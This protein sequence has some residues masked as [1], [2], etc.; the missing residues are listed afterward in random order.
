MGSSEALAHVAGK[1][2]TITAEMGAI[3]RS[4]LEFLINVS[5]DDVSIGKGSITMV[6][7]AGQIGEFKPSPV[8]PDVKNF[9]DPAR[10]DV[11]GMRAQSRASLAEMAEGLEGRQADFT[12][13]VHVRYSDEDVNMHVN[14]ASYV[15]FMEDARCALMASNHELANLVRKWNVR[16]ITIEYVSEAHAGDTCTLSIYNWKLAPQSLTLALEMVDAKT[17]QKRIRGLIEMSSDDAK[18]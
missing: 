8:P 7:V 10:S 4:S 13:T 11:L 12:H 2:L 15:R 3:G 14:H 1:C 6:S 16:S 18:L 5:C 9:A 17:Q